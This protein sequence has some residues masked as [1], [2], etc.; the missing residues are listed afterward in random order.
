M[1]SKATENRRHAELIRKYWVLNNQKPP[2]ETTTK[3]AGH[4]INN[5]HRDRKIR[6]GTGAGGVLSQQKSC[7]EM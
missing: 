1:I 6:G 5:G 7:Q 2:T 4:R 3:T